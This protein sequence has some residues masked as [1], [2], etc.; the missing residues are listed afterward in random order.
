MFIYHVYLINSILFI[1][2]YLMYIL[3][4]FFYIIKETKIYVDNV[5]NLIKFV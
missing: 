5:I 1:F 2:N 3:Q 4:I